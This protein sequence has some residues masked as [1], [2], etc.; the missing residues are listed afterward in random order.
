MDMDGRC[1]KLGFLDPLQGCGV[2]GN[3][4]PSQA[5]KWIKLAS[6]C[7]WVETLASGRF[8]LCGHEIHELIE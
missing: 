4:E 1:R 3:V 6:M 2:L 8:K 5:R 7:D